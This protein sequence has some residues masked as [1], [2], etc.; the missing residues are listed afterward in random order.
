[1][2]LTAPRPIPLGTPQGDYRHAREAL[3]QAQL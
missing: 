3:F 2:A 1:M